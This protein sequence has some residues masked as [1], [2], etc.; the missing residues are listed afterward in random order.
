M[1][2]PRTSHSRAGTKVYS[3]L[4]KLCHTRQTTPYICRKE[5]WL[6]QT[7]GLSGV[8]YG[9][10]YR[11][12]SNLSNLLMMMTFEADETTVKSSAATSREDGGEGHRRSV[13]R[14]CSFHTRHR[15]LPPPTGAPAWCVRAHGAR[16]APPGR[17]TRQRRCNVPLSARR[18]CLGHAAAGPP[19]GPL[20]PALARWHR[21]APHFR[22][23]GFSA[24]SIPRDGTDRYTPPEKTTDD[25][26][27]EQQ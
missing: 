24:A 25:I 16:F 5:A 18:S 7:V 19:A 12:S 13:C 22:A 17:I 1:C 11:P 23:S 20:S 21:V 3:T 4:E 10:A 14:P 27:Q 15:C 6:D 26:L 8:L 9:R 2:V